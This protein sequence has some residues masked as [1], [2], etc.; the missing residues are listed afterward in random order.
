MQDLAEAGLGWLYQRYQYRL[1]LGRLWLYRLWIERLL[2]YPV[3]QNINIGYSSDCCCNGCMRIKVLRKLPLV[4]CIK[5]TNIACYWINYCF[6]DGGIVIIGYSSQNINIGR[7]SNCCGNSCMICK[8]LRKL[9]LV[10]CIKVPMLLAVVSIP[11]PE[12]VIKLKSLP[13]SKFILFVPSPLNERFSDKDRPPTISS[14]VVGFEVPIPTFPLL[15]KLK[16][17]GGE[18]WLSDQVP[19]C[20]LWIENLLLNKSILPKHR[21]SLYLRLLR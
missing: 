7:S 2:N 13:L 12:E 11:P 1:L 20:R 6:V 9:G 21:Y 15:F 16:I 8:I 19:L 18:T 17:G 10:G 4:G 5:G 14:F 3:L